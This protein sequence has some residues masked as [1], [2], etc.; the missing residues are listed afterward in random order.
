MSLLSSLFGST[1]Q[2]EVQVGTILELTNY[3]ASLASNL[4]SIDPFLD[5]VRRITASVKPGESPTA[6]DNEALI[7]VYLHI[8]EY[9]ITKEPVRSFSKEGLRAH[10]APD[11]RHQ[12]ENYEVNPKEK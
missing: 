1:K 11:L 10:I 6:S 8:E 9:L 3:A 2:Q 7:S 5:E 12:I 4:E